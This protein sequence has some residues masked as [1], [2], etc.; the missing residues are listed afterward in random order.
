MPKWRHLLH[1]NAHYE[2]F[3]NAGHALFL[4]RDQHFNRSVKQWLANTDPSKPPTVLNT[5]SDSV[6]KG[7]GSLMS[8]DVTSVIS[9][10][11]DTLTGRSETSEDQS[12]MVGDST[13]NSAVKPPPKPSRPS[14]K[15]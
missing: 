14:N 9:S 4:E 2:I 8:S 3:R 1:E 15:R 13:S 5:F 6:S 11:W 12:S 7:I 10:I